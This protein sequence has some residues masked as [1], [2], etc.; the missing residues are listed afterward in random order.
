MKKI[1]KF[2]LNYII[3]YYKNRNFHEI[4]DPTRAR[5]FHSS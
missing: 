2:R 3:K 4:S 1:R 5:N